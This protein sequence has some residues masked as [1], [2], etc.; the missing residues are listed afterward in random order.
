MQ[1]C[2]V[3]GSISAPFEFGIPRILIPYCVFIIVDVGAGLPNITAWHQTLPSESESNVTVQEVKAQS[4]RICDIFGEC[5]SLVS[6]SDSRLVTF[7][8]KFARAFGSPAKSCIYWPYILVVLR[9]LS[10][11]FCSLKMVETCSFTKF[12]LAVQAFTVKF[13]PELF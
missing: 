5:T 12:P 7:V 13:A 8:S 11:R 1:V 6:Y 3:P 10:V 9:Y 4:E 2:P